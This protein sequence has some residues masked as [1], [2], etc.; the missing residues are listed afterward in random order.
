MPNETV[1]IATFIPKSSKRRCIRC[2][3]CCPQCMLSL[4]GIYSFARFF[5]SGS[6]FASPSIHCIFSECSR[7]CVPSERNCKPSPR[8][9]PSVH[10]SGLLKD[11]ICGY[12]Y[13]WAHTCALGYGRATKIYVDTTW[14]VA[15]AYEL[16]VRTLLDFIIF[17]TRPWNFPTHY[18]RI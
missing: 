13:A 14:L 17:C 6:F 3:S 8:T 9:R 4:L 16:F 12:F 18:E 11:N 10:F 1:S 2:R 15:K 7:K 5:M